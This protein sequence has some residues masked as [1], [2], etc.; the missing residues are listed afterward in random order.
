M[1]SLEALRRDVAI[2]HIIGN[3]VKLKDQQT[4][5]RKNCMAAY[6]GEKDQGS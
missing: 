2:G 4:S 6:F 5:L 3:S 1:V